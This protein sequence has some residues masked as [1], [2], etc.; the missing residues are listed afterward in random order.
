MKIETAC[1]A[2]TGLS[3]VN[4]LVLEKEFILESGCLKWNRDCPL[5]ARKKKLEA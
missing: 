2:A 4:S 5:D 3:A 1:Y